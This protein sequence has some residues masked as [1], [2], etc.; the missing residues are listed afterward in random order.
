M[1][2]EA[3]QGMLETD[4]YFIPT[5]LDNCDVPYHLSAFQW[6][7]LFDKKQGMKRLVEAMLRGLER[8]ISNKP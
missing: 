7:D 4:I 3:A 5:R 1:A 2:L 8:R 6:V